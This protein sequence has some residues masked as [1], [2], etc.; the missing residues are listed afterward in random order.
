MYACVDE[1]EYVSVTMCKVTYILHHT[2]SGRPIYKHVNHR[3]ISERTIILWTK[4]T[5]F[6][7]KRCRQM[8][9]QWGMCTLVSY[10]KQ[11]SRLH[12]HWQKTVKDNDSQ[13]KAPILLL[14]EENVMLPAPK[15]RLQCC[16][17]S[18]TRATKVIH[19][20]WMKQ[21]HSDQTQNC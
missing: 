11:Y 3:R 2:S 21:G 10:E 8:V 1:E 16:G 7:Q 14:Y 9:K 13:L 18:L 12:A 5:I 15:W 17:L 19:K 4:K 20:D 6:C